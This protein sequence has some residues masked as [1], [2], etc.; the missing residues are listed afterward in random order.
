MGI[1]FNYIIKILLILVVLYAISAIFNYVQGFI[2][3]GVSQKVAYSLRKDISAKMNRLPL[4]YFDKHSSGDILSRVTND[5]DTIAQS[6][7]SPYHS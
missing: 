3:S 1:D 7:N 4:S 6:L 2:V 5:I